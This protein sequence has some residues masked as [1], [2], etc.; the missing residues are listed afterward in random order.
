MT[1]VV[2]W[3]NKERDQKVLWGVADTRITNSSSDG[4]ASR[5]LDTYPKIF[6]LPIKV[7]ADLARVRYSRIHSYGI[8]FA[9]STLLASATKEI[10]T[11]L[12]S[13]LSLN[14][15]L[16]FDEPINL[17]KALTFSIQE[18]NEFNESLRNQLPALSEFVETIKN[19]LNQVV[20]SYIKNQ[21][22]SDFKNLEFCIFG[23]CLQLKK[24]CAYTLTCIMFEDKDEED[25]PFK[26]YSI[27]ITSKIFDENSENLEFILLGDRKELISSLIEEKKQ[28]LESS[29]VYQYWR[30]PCYVMEDIID[31]DYLLT[32]GSSAQL[33]KVND[34]DALSV[35]ISTKNTQMNYYGFKLLKFEGEEFTMQGF[36]NY[37]FTPNTLELGFKE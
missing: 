5:I 15:P 17:L 14:T 4:S 26:N 27:N 24:F 7:S 34:R 21:P 13:N 18:T 33:L 20:E 36:R 31:E 3:L 8:A 23:Y 11:F 19:V 16:N 1:S 28:E 32:I 25:K 29:R 37:G 10:V 35:G 12:C 22:Y 30:T 9:G 2:I 6:E